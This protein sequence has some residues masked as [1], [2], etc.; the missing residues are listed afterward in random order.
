M[1]FQLHSIR[2]CSRNLIVIKVILEN[3]VYISIKVIFFNFFAQTV[4]WYS[5]GIQI[6]GNDENTKWIYVFQL[7]SGLL[8]VKIG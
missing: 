2:I 8:C 6:G 4:S 7:Y 1:R 3:I 5:Y